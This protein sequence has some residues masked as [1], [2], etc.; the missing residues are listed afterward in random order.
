LTPTLKG[1]PAAAAVSE[2]CARRSENRDGNA[3]GRVERDPAGGRQVRGGDRDHGL[4]LSAQPR[5]FLRRPARKLLDL[6]K[7]D[8][9]KVRSGVRGFHRASMK[10][11]AILP[12]VPPLRLQ[13]AG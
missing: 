5:L 13:S 12:L 6:Q 11:F 4:Q 8:A 7:D 9:G 2:R 3:V 1:S 10:G